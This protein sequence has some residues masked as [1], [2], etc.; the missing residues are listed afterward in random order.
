[1]K[2][3]LYKFL[4]IGLI[5]PVLLLSFYSV[6]SLAKDPQTAIAPGQQYDPAEARVADVTILTQKLADERT[7]L[8]Y[9]QQ[10]LENQN[11]QQ[12]AWLEQFEPASFTPS[13]IDKARMSLNLT[14]IQLDKINITIAIVEENITAIQNNIRELE[15]R[16]LSLTPEAQGE[17]QK[18]YASVNARLAHENEKLSLERE[19]ETTLLA[20]QQV[21]EAL[22]SQ[23]A[24]WLDEMYGLARQYAINEIMN[25]QLATETKIQQ[26]QQQWEEKLAKARQ[27]L[28][29]LPMV[30]EQS[31]NKNIQLQDAIVEAEENIQL[32]MIRFNFS[33]ISTYSEILMNYPPEDLSR[34]YMQTHEKL[35]RLITELDVID[36]LIADKQLLLQKHVAVINSAFTSGVLDRRYLEEQLALFNQLIKSYGK[37]KENVDA[38]HAGI[39]DFQEKLLEGY[40]DTWSNRQALPRTLFEWKDLAQNLWTLPELTL[41]TLQGL[42]GQVTSALAQGDFFLWLRIILLETL[43]IFFGIHTYRYLK[44][45]LKDHR[46]AKPG[47]FGGT[48]VTLAQLFYRNTIGLIVFGGIMG[49]L[50]L[51]G[52]SRSSLIVPLSLGIVWFVFKFMI[53][54][55]RLSLFE[56]IWDISGQDVKLY[57]G[58]QWTLGIGGF[59]TAMAV[60]AHQLPVA[61]QVVTTYDRLFMLV[62]LAISFPLLKRWRVL[63]NLIAP[64]VSKKVYIKRAILLLGFLVPL[65]IFSNAMIGLVG[66]INLAWEIGIAEAKLLCVLTLWWLLRGVLNDFM[67]FISDLFIRKIPNGWVWTEA[68]LKPLHKVLNFIVAIGAAVLLFLL[69]DWNQES[70]VAQKIIALGKQELFAFGDLSITL[71]NIIQFVILVMIIRWAARWSREFAYRWLYSGAK[72]PGVRNSLSVFTQYATVII[73]AFIILRVLGID[74]T[75]LAVVAGALAVGIGFGLQNI[76]NNLISGLLLLIERPMRAGDTITLGTYEGEVTHIGMRA[77]TIKSWDNME[78]IIPNAEAVSKPLTNWTHHDTIVRTVFTLR[79]GFNENPHQVQAIIY[80]VVTNH[81]AVVSQPKVEIFLLEFG[82]SAMVFE[83]RYHI[84]LTYCNSRPQVRSE[85]LFA[86]WDSLKTAGIDLPYPRQEVEVSQQPSQGS[87]KGQYKGFGQPLPKN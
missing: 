4:R 45:Y 72:D 17:A 57:R 16:L 34:E 66:Y 79:I 32:L 53:S 85:I 15:K 30:N 87:F 77:T 59:V 82:E 47:T 74:L 24:A 64:Y 40:F 80:R 73:G 60:L 78:V 39:V 86:L 18:Q 14:Q 27:A 81:P 76:A 55:A 9:A 51:L 58:L 28:V 6:N 20:L 33:R 43:W 68:L 61:H 48:T 52:L 56:N 63:P 46:L 11:A 62:L 50:L 54:M 5:I 26:Q 21:M 35:D 42:V 22:V 41:H 84:D 38:L 3:S 1:M 10:Q 12:A 37:E 7:Q 83:I 36:K 29:E 2:Y 75:T 70:V 44:K 19:R 65:T 49:L 69:Y 8:H 13:L 25:K 23:H 67:D 71:F 31:A